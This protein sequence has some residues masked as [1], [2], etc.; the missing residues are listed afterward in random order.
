MAED[1]IW[2]ASGALSDQF[3]LLETRYQL[4][5]RDSA[6]VAPL[7]GMPCDEKPIARHR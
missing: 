3:G 2:F 4:P 7:V 5:S 6:F 1:R